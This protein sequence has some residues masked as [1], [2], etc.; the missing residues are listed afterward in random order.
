MTGAGT[1]EMDTE[2]IKNSLK[3]R[4]SA[5]RYHHSLQVAEAAVS[6]AK[7]YGADVEKAQFAGLVHDVCKD[8][9]KDRL[10]QM[11]GDF[12][13]ILTKSERL[14]PKLWHA[15]VG[16]AYVRKYLTGD[17]EIIDAV[18]YHTTA[19]A[20]MSLLEKVVYVADCI[21]ADR[22]F[23]GVERLRALAGQS[24]DGAIWEMTR[25]TLEELS[26]NGAP[27]HEDTVAAYNQLCV[28][29]A[30]ALY[31]NQEQRQ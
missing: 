12:A 25:M 24:L 26:E 29:K 9:T 27:L 28:S 15:I 18:R 20:D 6:L 13:I 31:G 22:D 21:S 7:R 3:S 17:I 11:A 8:E 10:L 30:E 4:L 5:K 16:A 14:C 1:A 2:S 23:P 19:K